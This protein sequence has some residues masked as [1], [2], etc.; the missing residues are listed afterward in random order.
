L[1]LYKRLLDSLNEEKL[2]LQSID[3]WKVGSI[4]KMSNPHRIEELAEEYNRL[5]VIRDFLETAIAMTTERMT[6]IQAEVATLKA[7]AQELKKVVPSPEGNS[8]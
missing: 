8:R 1:I 7:E 5:I 2:I 6:D 3:A 4:I